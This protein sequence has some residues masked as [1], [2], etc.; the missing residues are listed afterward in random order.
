MYGPHSIV[1]LAMR[2]EHSIYCNEWPYWTLAIV[3]MTLPPTSFLNYE[4]IATSLS[5]YWH[6]L[7]LSW[8]IVSSGKLL[9]FGYWHN[10]E[11]T[12]MDYKDITEQYILY[13]R[14]TMIW[15]TDSTDELF[16]LRITHVYIGGRVSYPDTLYRLI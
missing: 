5:T 1:K 4:V 13:M 15:Q 2:R 10:F 3:S 14:M 9:N 16:Q 6:Y 8:K 11:S 7:L 12:N